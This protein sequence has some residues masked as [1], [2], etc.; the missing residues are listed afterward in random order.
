MNEDV[1][2]DAADDGG[3]DEDGEVSSFKGGRLVG[4][5]VNNADVLGQKKPNDWVNKLVHDYILASQL[6][7]ED[8]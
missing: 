7:N 8:Y 3:V 5:L 2:T 6:G 4:S 1:D